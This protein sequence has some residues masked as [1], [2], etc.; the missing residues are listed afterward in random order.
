MCAVI[1]VGTLLHNQYQYLLKKYQRFLVE[2]N[3]PVF[4][5]A[6]AIALSIL[7]LRFIAIIIT[8]KPCKRKSRDIK[9]KMCRVKFFYGCIQMCDKH[10]AISH[11][12]SHPDESFLHY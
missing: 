4:K 9:I 8:F 2:D 7:G 1:F 12:L 6:A 10:I 11:L 3:F 5:I